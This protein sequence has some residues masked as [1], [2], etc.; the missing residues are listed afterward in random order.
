[1]G[2]QQVIGPG[3]TSFW[4]E[5]VSVYLMTDILKSDT[6][7]QVVYGWAGKYIDEA[8]KPLVDLQGDIIDP[9][10]IEKSAVDFMLEHRASGVMHEG[11][12]VGTIV[13]SLVTTPEIVKALFGADAKVPVGWLIGVKYPDKEVYKRVVSGEL[14]M[15]S[16]QGSADTEDAA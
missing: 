15:F 7:Q 10:E 8:G 5:L 12:A 1:M 2:C 3:E 6:T 4:E 14:S 11:K 13:A 16:I 9:E